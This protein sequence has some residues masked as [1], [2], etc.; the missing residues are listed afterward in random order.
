M[1]VPLQLLLQLGLVN[2]A[3][4]SKA[5]GLVSVITFCPKQLLISLTNT[6]YDPAHKPEGFWGGG[7][8]L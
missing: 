7:S 6:V 5:A 2:D 3:F 8:G 1:A 4:A